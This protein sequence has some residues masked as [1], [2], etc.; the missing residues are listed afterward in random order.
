MNL[1]PTSIS[2]PV[3]VMVENM[4]SEQVRKSHAFLVKSFLEL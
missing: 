2:T 3:A 1:T 4:I